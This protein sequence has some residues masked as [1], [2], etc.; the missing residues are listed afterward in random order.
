MTQNVIRVE[1]LRRQRTLAKTVD[2]SGFGYW[3]GQD[4]V[5]SFRPAEPNA[6]IRFIRDDLQNSPV[7][8]ARV[9][10]RVKKP[11][12]TSL[13]VGKAQVDMVEHALA[14]LRAARIDNCDVVV[15]APEAP[16][17]DGSAAAYLTAFLEAGYIEQDA[18]RIT[19]KIDSTITLANLNGAQGEL[20]CEPNAQN[21]MICSYQL[22][23]DQPRCIPNQEACFDCSCEPDVFLREIANCRTFLTLEEAEYL[24]NAGMCQRVS[25]KDALVFGPQGPIENV[26][27]F[28]NECARHKLLDFMGDFALAPVDWIGEF[29]ACKT[30]HEQ[31]AGALLTLLQ[32]ASLM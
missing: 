17:L 18:E 7:I 1:S 26:L 13:A 16:G 31:N 28:P 23:Y 12:Q 20:R 10:N 25:V 4:V 15:T 32:E 22:L 9:E 2:I 29:Y 14:A 8:P 19:V 24:R 3:T 30:G 27:R 6:G 11:R 5:F 21:R